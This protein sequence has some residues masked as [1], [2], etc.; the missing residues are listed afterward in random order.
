M[1]VEIQTL[2]VLLEARKRCSSLGEN[3]IGECA[4]GLMLGGATKMIDGNDLL[5]AG[6]LGAG[7]KKGGGAP[8]EAAD[9]D[10]GADSAALGSQLQQDIAF[11]VMQK[12]FDATQA[13]LPSD[14]VGE[15]GK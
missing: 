6:Q 7:G 11:E 4:S 8:H 5:P 9:F 3:G 10:D 13:L 12:T 15:H 2:Q 1:V 14:E